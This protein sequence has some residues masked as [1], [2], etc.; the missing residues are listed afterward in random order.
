MKHLTLVYDQDTIVTT[1]KAQAILAVPKAL[2]SLTFY[3]NDC[4][5]L[6]D[7]GNS[8]DSDDP[9]GRDQSVAVSNSQILHH[10]KGSYRH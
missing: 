7:S 8:D 2:S 5:I 1:P 6:P 3:Q 9:D 10:L 4:M